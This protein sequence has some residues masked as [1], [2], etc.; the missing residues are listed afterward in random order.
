MRFASFTEGFGK[1]FSLFALGLFAGLLFTSLSLRFLTLSRA[2]L[3]N[4]LQERASF[5][6]RCFL[7]QNRVDQFAR[8]CQVSGALGRA[9]LGECLRDPVALLPGRF[10]ESRALQDLLVEVGSSGMLWIQFQK[11]LDLGSRPF[12]ISGLK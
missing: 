11:R 4:L 2:E 12:V 9:R 10:F 6:V 7:F 5:R 1:P 8:F 3:I